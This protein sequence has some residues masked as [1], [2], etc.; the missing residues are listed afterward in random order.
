MA[1]VLGGQGKAGV[2][3]MSFQS[4][5][6]HQVIWKSLFL[7]RAAGSA[8]VGPSRCPSGPYPEAWLAPG[9]LPPGQ[10]LDGT[11]GNDYA[12]GSRGGIWV[13]WGGYEVYTDIF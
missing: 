11:A 1:T 7:P 3:D 6:L 4:L 10:G 8:S 9:P 2:E 13:G 5:C 12:V